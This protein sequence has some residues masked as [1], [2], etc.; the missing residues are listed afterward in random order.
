MNGGAD[1]L[2]GAAAADV[3]A[4][5]GIDFG[6]RRLRDPCEQGRSRHDLPGLTVAALR[7]IEL[8]PG[9]LYGV[10]VVGREALDGDNALAAGGAQRRYAGTH[11]RTFQVHCAGTTQRHTAAVLG[12]SQSDDVAQRPQQRHVAIGIESG[13]PAVENESDHRLVG[14]RAAATAYYTA[15]RSQRASCVRGCHADAARTLYNAPSP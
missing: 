6:I 5:G 3:A 13:I 7:N 12:A 1:A 2:I 10:T 4:H 8:D 15:A 14:P 11:R 9:A